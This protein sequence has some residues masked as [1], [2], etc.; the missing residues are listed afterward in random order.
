MLVGFVAFLS[1]F[2]TDSIRTLLVI[3]GLPLSLMAAAYTAYLFAQAKGRDLWQ[4]PL[5]PPHMAVQAVLVEAPGLKLLVDTCVGND[6]PRRPDSKNSKKAL[7]RLTAAL[8]RGER[9]SA[10]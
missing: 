7:P 4:S 10:P 1:L 9:I 3:A 6:K 8:A 2:A 5:L